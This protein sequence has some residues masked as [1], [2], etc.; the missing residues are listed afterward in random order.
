MCVAT[1]GIGV[2]N[3]HRRPKINCRQPNHQ[4][5]AMY[6]PICKRSLQHLI[7][8]HGLKTVCFVRLSHS[9][10]SMFFRAYVR[11]MRSVRAKV[12]RRVRNVRQDEAAVRQYLS[13]ENRISCRRGCS[14][15]R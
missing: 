1:E 13:P 5:K 10:A 8:P 12:V 9:E 3:F 4:L 2:H 7:N 15:R 6:P 14:G 11:N